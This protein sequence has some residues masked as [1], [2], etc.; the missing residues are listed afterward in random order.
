MKHPLLPHQSNELFMTDGGLETTMIFHK[1][2]T[3]P[4]FASFILLN[5]QQ[6]RSNL[7]D[8]F[9]GYLSVAEQHDCVMI[10]DTPTWRA[11][12]DWTTLL[13]L[14]DAQAHQVNTQAT[15]LMQSIQAGAPRT[16]SVISGCI[17]PR[18]DGYS[19][20]QQMDQNQAFYYHLP[21][22]ESLYRAGVDLISALTIN[23]EYEAVGMVRAA[24]TC[25]VP[26]AISF[27]TETN[28][29]LPNGTSIESAIQH[30][31]RITGYGPAYYM[32]NCAHPIHFQQALAAGE[33]WTR[34]IRGIRLNASTKSHAELDACDTLDDGDP[35]ELAKQ[36][37]SLKST[38][39]GINI[40][41]GCCGTDTRHLAAMLNLCA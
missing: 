18:Y 36:V 35:A 2:L 8:Y 6:G 4:H 13:G 33:A 23:Y 29:K 25:G 20:A 32:I 24:Q 11:S 26:I 28:G 34:R 7:I 17:G 37:K 9:H 19:A 1:G 27:T 40:I 16:K 39:Q 14:D 3:L 31:D 10:L 30:V 12:S 41:G 22:I 15:A 38:H 5:D 21:Q